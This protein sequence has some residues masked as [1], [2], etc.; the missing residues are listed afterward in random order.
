MA[1]PNMGRIASGKVRRGQPPK[2]LSSAQLAVQGVSNENVQPNRGSNP[3]A[4][5]GDVSK[6]VNSDLAGLDPKEMENYGKI[7]LSIR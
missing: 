2:M 1:N 4:A 6:M 5:N 3:V 7:S